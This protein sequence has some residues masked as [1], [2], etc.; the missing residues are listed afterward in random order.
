MHYELV[1]RPAGLE[2][3]TPWFVVRCSNP[4][5][6]RARE[7]ELYQKLDEAY[8]SHGLHGGGP[9][10]LRTSL[11]RSMRYIPRPTSDTPRPKAIR[12]WEMFDLRQLLPRVCRFGEKARRPTTTEDEAMEGQMI[13]TLQRAAS[14]TAS[15]RAHKIG[16]KILTTRLGEGFDTAFAVCVLLGALWLLVSGYA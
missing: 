3:T 1:A 13:A 11:A 15:N 6:L 10:N 16:I 4:T 12:Y 2:P 14:A 8:P 9:C 7:S 5:E